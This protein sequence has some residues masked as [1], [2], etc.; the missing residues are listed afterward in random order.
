MPWFLFHNPPFKSTFHSV[1]GDPPHFH[2]GSGVLGD[3]N[4]PGTECDVIDLASI[5]TALLAEQQTSVGQKL[6]EEDNFTGY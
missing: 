5:Y 1:E 2:S 3:K 6:I 4:N